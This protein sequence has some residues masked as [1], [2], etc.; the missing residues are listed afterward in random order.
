MRKNILKSHLSAIAPGLSWSEVEA[1][2]HK[3]MK[4]EPESYPTENDAVDAAVIEASK[5]K[6]SIYD[7]NQFKDVYD[8]F[9]WTITL[10][11]AEDPK[12]AVVA[13]LVQGGTSANA[14]PLVRDIIGE[15]LLNED[16]YDR[17]DFTTQMQ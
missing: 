17:A 5:G 13:V 2:M 16:K 1:E 3:L 12:I 15:Y 8:P 11:P 4:E 9:A 10:A 14:G 6:V 7:I